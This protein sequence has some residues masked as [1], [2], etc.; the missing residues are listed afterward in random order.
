MSF[1]HPG[2]AAPASS[3]T[4]PRR[5]SPRL[6]PEPRQLAPLDMDSVG[7]VHSLNSNTVTPVSLRPRPDSAVKALGELYSK[8]KDDV[9]VL[10]A[11]L[12]DLERVEQVVP[13]QFKLVSASSG[14]TLLCARRA[15]GQTEQ[16]WEWSHEGERVEW[17][18]CRWRTEFSYSEEASVERYEGPSA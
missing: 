1:V 8:V 16:R 15:S 11:A 17:A 5:S 9:A 10:V 13:D 4:P 14:Y 6:L 2:P 18:S 12:V 3:P 7:C